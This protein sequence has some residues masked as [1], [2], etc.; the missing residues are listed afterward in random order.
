MGWFFAYGKPKFVLGALAAN[1]LLNRKPRNAPPAQPR[2]MFQ[3]YDEYGTAVGQAVLTTQEMADEGSR[4]LAAQ[5]CN[6]D[7]STPPPVI[8]MPV[9]QPAERF[10]YGLFDMGC[11]I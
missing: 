1:W 9:F 6:C 8:P 11:S 7:L 4:E 10:T 3:A 5:G 2:L